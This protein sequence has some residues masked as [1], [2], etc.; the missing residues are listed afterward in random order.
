VW[1]PVGKRTI[2]VVVKPAAPSAEHP[3]AT[4]DAA[5]TRATASDRTTREEDAIEAS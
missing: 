3:A 2:A 1:K 4:A 5:T